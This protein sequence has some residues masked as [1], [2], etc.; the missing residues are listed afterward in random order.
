[1]QPIWQL[2]GY[3]RTA[4]DL[5]ET[6]AAVHEILSVPCFPEMTDEEVARVAASLAAF[7]VGSR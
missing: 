3:R 6:H 4:D 2:D 1:M 5:S 7:R